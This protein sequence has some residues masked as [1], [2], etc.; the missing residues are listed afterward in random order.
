M[1]VIAANKRARFDYAIEQRLTAGIVL[2]GA[3]T[4]SIKLGH[5]SLKG[6]F[7]SLFAGEAYLNNAHVT[8]YQNATA[9]GEAPDRR[10]KLL[11]HRRQLGELDAAR[12]AGLNVVPLAIGQERGLVKVELGIGRGQRRYDKRASL[13]ARQAERDVG[14]AIKG[15]PAK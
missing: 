8:P 15:R 14:R 1:K 7:V 4:K 10:R 6:S 3:E 2:S 11:L 12:G 5:V 13:K 9:P